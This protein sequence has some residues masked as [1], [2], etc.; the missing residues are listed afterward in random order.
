MHAG[1]NALVRYDMEVGHGV[2]MDLDACEC[3][4]GGCLFVQK[5]FFLDSCYVLVILVHDNAVELTS[6]DLLL[7]RCRRS[8]PMEHFSWTGCATAALS[9]R[10]M[11]AAISI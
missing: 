8:A 11:P 10:F 1:N 6:V 7:F 3:I 2:D 4:F 9:S 5:R